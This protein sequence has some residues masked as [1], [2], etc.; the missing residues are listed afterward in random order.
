[1]QLV[2]VTG[3]C[4]GQVIHLEAEE[5][6]ETYSV[7]MAVDNELGKLFVKYRL[8]YWNKQEAYYVPFAW[9]TGYAIKILLEMK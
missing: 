5:A 7:E 4:H 6:P 8:V 1:M 2:L 3:A 9:H